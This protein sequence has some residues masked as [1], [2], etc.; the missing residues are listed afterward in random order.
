[1]ACCNNAKQI[2]LALHNY[3]DDYGCFPSA[4]VA[5]KD[6]KP[7]HSWRALLLPFIEE[8]NLYKQYNFNEPWNGPNNHKLSK[9][10]ICGLNCP[11][12]NNPD[13]TITNYVAVT[14]PGTIWAGDK[15]TRI[16]DITDGTS[17]TILLVEMADSDIGWMEPRDVTLAEALGKSG[18][19]VTTVPNSNHCTEDSYFF[20][21][22]PLP[23]HIVMADGS[24]RCLCKRP[25][26]KDLAALLSINEGETVDIDLLEDETEYPFYQRLRWDHVIGL[27]LF[28][29]A[30]VCFWFRLFQ[31]RVD[32][33]D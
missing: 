8:N 16:E 22:M 9:E 29:V 19:G 28:L 12:C 7:M 30:V 18:D 32:S 5:D 1:M 15:G 31:E 24:V 3:H 23:G 11:S 20:K 25:S 13:K 26:A 10:R 6:G 27:P 2:A 14:G 17:K 4:Y 21:G 33:E